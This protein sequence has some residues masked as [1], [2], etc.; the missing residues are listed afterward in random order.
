MTYRFDNPLIGKAVSQ[1]LVDRVIADIYLDK[2]LEA[3]IKA[4]FDTACWTYDKDKHYIFVGDNIL[5]A[6][7]IARD[8][9][10]DA[11][12]VDLYKA[13][14]HHELAHAHWTARNFKLINAMCEKAGAPFSLFNLME[15][16]RIEEKHR[17]VY[18]QPLGWKRFSSG[19]VV[20]NGAPQA[21][22]FKMVEEETPDVEASSP[23]LYE[24]VRAFYDRIIAAPDSLSLRP[25]LKE[26]ADTFKEQSQ[27]KQQQSGN[28][29]QANAGSSQSNPSQGQG[30]PKASPEDGQ[31]PAG[32]NALSDR[33]EMSVGQQLAQNPDKLAQF[34]Q[35]S[36]DA[37]EAAG[38]TPSGN[39]RAKGVDKDTAAYK[40]AS[41]PNRIDPAEVDKLASQLAKLMT[42]L[43]RQ[44]SS[45]EPT[46]RLNK[47][48]IGNPNLP[49]YKKKELPKKKKLNITLIVD[50]SGSMGGQPEQD[51]T[52]LAAALHLLA[53]R[54]F[55]EG[56]VI[57]STSNQCWAYDIKDEKAVTEVYARASAEGLERSMGLNE[58]QL[59]HSDAVLVFTDGQLADSPVDKKLWHAKGIHTIGLY[60]GSMEHSEY[61]Q[62][63]FDKSIIRE[64]IAE[65]GFA[66]QKQFAKTGLSKDGGR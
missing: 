6:E 60:T 14:M 54:G 3:R 52:T 11:E 35:D 31:K 30:Q 19:P 58:Q 28:S 4:N 56:K 21:L 17:Q 45:T 41:R 22:L 34:M 37:Q 66:L 7:R 57:A 59:R 44:V 53:L 10:T 64:N 20:D 51:A 48:A 61:L 12:K 23:E 39:P 38:Q 36:V 47:R 26:W 55:V 40:F 16:C 65:L 63:Y 18:G 24:K 32:G 1:V 5:P 62:Q 29:G 25:I 13:F 8:N 50:C 15:D 42:T 27:Q 2:P 46:Q 49:G 9:L 33:E 43:E